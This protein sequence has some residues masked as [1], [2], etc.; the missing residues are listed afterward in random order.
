MIYIGDKVTVIRGGR[1]LGN[2]LKAGQVVRVIEID[3]KDGAC[4]VQAGRETCWIA[5][6]DLREENNGQ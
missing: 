4:K 2:K 1:S 6:R 5:E 3:R